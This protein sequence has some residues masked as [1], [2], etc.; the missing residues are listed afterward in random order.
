MSCCEEENKVLEYIQGDTFD[1]QVVIETTAGTPVDVS[2]ISKVVFLL[3]DIDKRVE[4]T[5]EL[6]YDTD[7]GKWTISIPTDT[8]KEGTHIYR[9]RVFYTDGHKKT[10]TMG[11]IQ[12]TK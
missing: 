3:V 1:R 8:W 7:I 9:Y 12:V 4:D 11:N 5:A 6:E 2:Y 10:K